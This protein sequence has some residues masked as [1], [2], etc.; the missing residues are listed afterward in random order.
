MEK[1]ADADRLFRDLVSAVQ[2]GDALRRV[3]RL[4]IGCSGG[5]DSCVLL[6]LLARCSGWQ[7][8]L[9]VAHLHHGW[10][11]READADAQLV[12]QLAARHRLPCFV[13]RRRLRP[14]NGS[15]EAAGRQARLD[16]FARTGRQWRADA[17]AL[18][19]TADDQAETVLLNLVRG[20]GKRGLGGMRRRS[21]VG[22]LLIVRPLLLLRRR[23]L[24]RYAEAR[25]LQWREDSSNTLPA[26]T[27]NRVRSELLPALETVSVDAVANLN[28]AARL[29]SDEED[30]LDG[31]T[32]T[33]FARLSRPAGYPG[34]VALDMGDLERLPRAQQRRLVRRALAAVRGD[35]SGVSQSHVEAVLHR[36]LAGAEQARDLPGVRAQRRDGKLRFLPLRGRR[37]AETPDPATTPGAEARS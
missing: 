21:R 6:D 25:D 31:L 20:T 1:T 35:L 4:L 11:G 26:F 29:L 19:H 5:A 34:A 17:V 2:Q 33:L 36:V 18:G 37:L 32:E 8:A 13:E 9:A 3:R 27:R 14:L 12:R 24:L 22:G 10:R 7:L 16:F 28:R 23:Q 15:L 30:W